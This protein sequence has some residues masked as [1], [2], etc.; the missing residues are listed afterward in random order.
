[1][2]ITEAEDKLSRDV[3]MA[4]NLSHFKIQKSF[5][6]LRTGYWTLIHDI[7]A[8]EQGIN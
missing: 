2:I 7:S 3:L 1:M 8:T 6:L 4:F 5:T